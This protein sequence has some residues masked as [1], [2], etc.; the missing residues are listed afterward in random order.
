MSFGTGH[1]YQP[2]Q[3]AF[4]KCMTIIECEYFPPLLAEGTTGDCGRTQNERVESTSVA[5]QDDFDPE[6]FEQA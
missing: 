6:L 2:E 5:G 3:P 4:Y 1:I